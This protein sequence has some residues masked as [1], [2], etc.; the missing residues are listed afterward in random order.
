MKTNSNKHIIKHGIEVVQTKV[1][2]ILQLKQENKCHLSEMTLVKN[3]RPSTNVQPLP[4]K[5]QIL[6]LH[7]NV[8]QQ[9]FKIL[10]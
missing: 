10:L 6:G 2:K 4:A 3:T 1:V 7:L 5:T 9:I 8:T